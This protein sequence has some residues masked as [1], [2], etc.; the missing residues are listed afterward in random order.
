MKADAIEVFRCAADMCNE[1][2][3][4][5]RAACLFLDVEL[6]SAVFVLEV[7]LGRERRRGDIEQVREDLL[8]AA[9]RLEE[10]T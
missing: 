4:P 3:V 8:E 2:I 5:L 10:R 9:Q 7:T 1:T 6:A